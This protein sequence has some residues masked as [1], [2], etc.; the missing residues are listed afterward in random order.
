MVMPGMED[1]DPAIIL[2]AMRDLSFLAICPQTEENQQKLEDMMP[3]MEIPKG[4]YVAVD[5]DCHLGKTF[6]RKTK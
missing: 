6:T 3:L 2:T 5:T 4:E 1:A